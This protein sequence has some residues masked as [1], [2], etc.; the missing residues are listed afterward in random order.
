FYQ[1]LGRSWNHVQHLLDAN[2]RFETITSTSVAFVQGT[3][4]LVIVDGERRTTVQAVTD[5]V[6]VQS[7]TWEIPATI[8]LDPGFGTFVSANAPPAPPAAVAA[9]RLS[10]QLD[11]DG[12]ATL[13]ATDAHNR[14]VGVRPQVGTYGSQVPGA[15]EQ[16][17][18]SRPALRI[19]DPDASY[20]LTLSALGE[21][22]SLTVTATVFVDGAAAA[23]TRLTGDVRPGG[24]LGTRLAISSLA[25]PPGAAIS[26]TSLTPQGAARGSQIPTE[27]AVA[28]TGTPVATPTASA[29]AT[30]ESTADTQADPIAE[31]PEESAS[32]AVAPALLDGI[33]DTSTAHTR[34]RTPITTNSSTATRTLTL[35]TITMPLATTEPRRGATP[36][37]SPET[38]AASKAAPAPSMALPVSPSPTA[39]PPTKELRATASPTATISINVNGVRSAALSTG[40]PASHSQDAEPTLALSDAEPQPHALAN[41]SHAP[42]VTPSSTKT[43]TSLPA[44]PTRT[45]T[46]FVRGEPP[47]RVAAP[48]A[49]PAAGA[50]H[51]PQPERHDDHWNASGHGHADD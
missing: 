26:A 49:T 44:T 9:P 20:D 27:S 1:Q 15:T 51:P 42:T 40:V 23:S 4:Y 14:S 21:G 48:T 34:T 47:T 11:V 33:P 41:G 25:I 19:P 24:L 3:E 22:G 30:P 13:L 43:P 32:L 18:G 39:T 50:H 10:L 36:T 31:N 12:P 17:A 8:I 38:V 37:S 7:T 45:P 46:R 5:A 28:A 35:R 29:T 16:T 6:A 2:S